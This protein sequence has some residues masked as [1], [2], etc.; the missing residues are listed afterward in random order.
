M[1]SV[2]DEDWCGLACNARFREE[3]EL[4]WDRVLPREDDRADS[5]W[6]GDRDGVCWCPVE[7]LG[8][9]GGGADGSNVGI[10]ACSPSGHLQM[11]IVQS[12]VDK[13]AGFLQ[14]WSI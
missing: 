2:L 5:A 3:E 7:L 10:M 11:P 12:W 13:R 9:V 14:D 8:P 4:A 1:A 6:D